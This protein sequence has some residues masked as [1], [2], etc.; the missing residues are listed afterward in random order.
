[1]TKFN[2]DVIDHCQNGPSI[3]DPKW[4]AAKAA[5]EARRKDIKRKLAAGIADD[6]TLS[7]LKSEQARQQVRRSK[8]YPPSKVKLRCLE[9]SLPELSK[10][11]TEGA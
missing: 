9:N 6:C 10:D 7:F 5:H 3:P 1:M 11:A 2:Q 4:T 8:L